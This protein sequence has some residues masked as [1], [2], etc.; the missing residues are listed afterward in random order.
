[1][2]DKDWRLYHY[3]MVKA[4]RKIITIMKD[5]VTFDVFMSHGIHY[6]ALMMNL[7]IIGENAQKLPETVKQKCLEVPWRDIIFMRHI[8]SHSYESLEDNTVWVTVTQKIPELLNQLLK[9]QD[10]NEDDGI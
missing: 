10:Y 3:N 4:C 9:I 5:D 6:D 2:S 7:Q 8:I 1:M